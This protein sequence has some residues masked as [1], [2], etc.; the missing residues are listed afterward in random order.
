MRMRISTTIKKGIESAAKTFLK[1]DIH[2]WADFF[3]I[4]CFFN[5]DNI[6]SQTDLIDR[7][8]PRKDLEGVE[9]NIKVSP[10]KRNEANA[11]LAEDVMSL[12]SYRKSVFTNFY[13]FSISE[14]EKSISTV[15][16]LTTEHKLYLSL[17]FSSS[18]G[19]FGDYTSKLTSSFERL[20]FE[21]LKTILPKQS[22]VLLFGSSN[23]ES[24]EGKAK[25]DLLWNKINLLAK[26]LR[27]TVNIKETDFSD[28]DRGDGGLDIYGWISLGDENRHFPIY[29]CQC[30]CTPEWVSKQHSSKYDVWS[31][32]ITL[33]IYPHNII[34]IPY[35]YRKSNGEWHDNKKIHKSIMMDRQRLIY[36]LKDENV[37]FEKFDS[38]KIVENL[39]NQ[40]EEVV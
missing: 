38:C 9:E 18:L 10:S 30:A 19:I 5:K 8:T 13:P 14:D 31:E 40:K 28:R 3:E 25:N 39:M 35:S 21:A 1:K 4:L 6:A 11:Q 23:V 12:I 26:N 29:F 16:D 37:S 33:A 36:L 34:F 32:L 27:E 7:L 15:S 2:N 17:V 24:L 20:S 22:N